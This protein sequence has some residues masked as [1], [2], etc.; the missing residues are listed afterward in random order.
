MNICLKAKVK[1][2]YKTVMQKFDREL[3]ELLAPKNAPMKIKKFTGSKKG[4]LVHI[5][6]KSPINTDWISDIVE[7]GANEKEAWFID[8]G[9][10]LPFPLKYWRHKHIVRK[11]DEEHSV[12][13]DDITFQGPN[14]IMDRLLYPAIYLGFKPRKRIYQDYFGKA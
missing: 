7:D 10:K 4:D 9:R 2:H 1:G 5:H 13:I 11:I 14:F 3:F 6:F 12:I 8:E